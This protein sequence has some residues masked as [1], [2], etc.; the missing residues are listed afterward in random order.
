L[1]KYIA[2]IAVWPNISS[3]VEGTTTIELL[4]ISLTNS[5]VV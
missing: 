3:Y 4:V 1:H 2:S 5:S